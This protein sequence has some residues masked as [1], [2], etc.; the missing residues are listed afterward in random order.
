MRVF[1][2]NGEEFKFERIRGGY[3]G[4][5]AS[6]SYYFGIDRAFALV[7]SEAF[8]QRKGFKIKHYSQVIAEWVSNNLV[9]FCLREDVS[10]QSHF[11][12]KRLNQLT[13]KNH[14]MLCL[15]EEFRT[16]PPVEE[17]RFILALQGIVLD[18]TENSQCAF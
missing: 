15:P 8:E 1:R 13:K 4:T 7:I 16:V 12:V 5:R 2:P 9:V 3:F 17:L 11:F 10:A 14:R 18:N 6:S